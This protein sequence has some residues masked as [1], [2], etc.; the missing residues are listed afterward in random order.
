LTAIARRR[1]TRRALGLGLAGLWAAGTLSGCGGATAPHAASPSG[2]SALAAYLQQ[3]EPLRL[4]V[5]RLLDQADPI[6][7][8]Y[9]HARLSAREASSRMGRLEQRFAGYAVDVA[10]IA[11]TTPALRALH[12]VY[13]HTYVLEDSYLSA[14]TAGLAQRKTDNLP[15]TQNDQRAA[16]IQWRIGL[17]VLARQLGFTL[18][19][20]LQQAGRG[21]IAPSPQGS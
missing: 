2:R 4:A 15:S 12:G 3:V 6:L 19:A 16:I 10:A 20:D 8:A 11:P 14:L 18:P 21:E 9:A 13:A 7:S 17:G 5:N 1:L